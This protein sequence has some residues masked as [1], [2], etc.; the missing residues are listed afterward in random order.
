MVKTVGSSPPGTAREQ[1]FS[2][3]S[4]TGKKIDKWAALKIGCFLEGLK[5]WDESP[6]KKVPPF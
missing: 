2:R 3:R 6:F 5:N 4:P 1:S